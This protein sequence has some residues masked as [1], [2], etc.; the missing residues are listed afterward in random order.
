[1]IVPPASNFS[2]SVARWSGQDYVGP[3]APSFQAN[4][5]IVETDPVCMSA[6]P[7]SPSNLG[8]VFFGFVFRYGVPTLA[9]GNRSS[10]PNNDTG[11]SDLSLPNLK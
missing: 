5:V 8:Q 7:T 6:M 11:K 3:P 4:G 2:A 1:M 9:W 10:L